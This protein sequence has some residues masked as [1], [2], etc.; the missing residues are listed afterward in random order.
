MAKPEAAQ[1]EVASSM[2]DSAAIKEVSDADNEVG[3]S[4]PETSRLLRKLD[5]TLLPFLSL[6]YLLSFL[7]RANIGNAK[8]AGLEKDLNMEG[9]DYSVSPKPP[10]T[11]VSSLSNNHFLTQRAIDSYRLPSPSSFPFTSSPRSRPTW[12]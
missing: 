7:D 12:P 5:R 8:L 9:Y 1:I 11:H 10:H 3:F 2:D 4:K 6:L